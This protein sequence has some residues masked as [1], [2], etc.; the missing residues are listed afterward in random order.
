MPE[1]SFALILTENLNNKVLNVVQTESVVSVD[2]KLSPREI[3]SVRDAVSDSF[4][5]RRKNLN[6][7]ISQAFKDLAKANSAKARDQIIGTF[8]ADM[9]KSLV[10]FDREMQKRVT[11]AVEETKGIGEKAEA[12]KWSFVVSTA[13]SVAKLTGDGIKLFAEAFE[14]VEAPN[15]SGAASLVK[16]MVD[17]TRGVVEFAKGIR[18]AWRGVKAQEDLVKATLDKIR[19]TKK[20]EPVSLS[21][22]NKA[23]DQLE[24]LGKKIDAL[25]KQADGL[26]REVDQMLKLKFE[27]AFEASTAKMAEAAIDE[28][29]KALSELNKEIIARRKFE[30]SADTSIKVAK[31]KAKA[32]ASYWK[33]WAVAAYDLVCDLS[34]MSG[35]VESL[36]DCVTKIKTTSDRLEQAREELESGFESAQEARAEL[37]KLLN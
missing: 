23:E 37:G 17:L 6:D 30:K 18:D 3:A 5:A 4:M 29:L 28:T 24:K 27:K 25:E 14:V 9:T 26:S 32:D 33:T 21:E 1:I 36:W 22:V 7:M 35:D 20:G 2:G 13:W 19:K 15:L 8:N 11:K 16:S 31:T 10:T 12:E 34:D